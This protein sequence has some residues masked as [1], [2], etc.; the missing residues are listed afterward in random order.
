VLAIDIQDPAKAVVLQLV[1]PIG[2]TDRLL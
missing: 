1:D 2:M